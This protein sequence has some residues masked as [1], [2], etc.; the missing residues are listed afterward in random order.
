MEAISTAQ[1]DGEVPSMSGSHGNPSHRSH[2]RIFGRE[3]RVVLTTG[4][5]HSTLH[6]TQRQSVL[7][8]SGR[9][10]IDN[11]SCQCHRVE[12]NHAKYM[13]NADTQHVFNHILKTLTV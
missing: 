4:L 13:E 1:M 11:M 2:H 12:T 3:L 6:F 9:G 8:S 7:S 5:P 10:L